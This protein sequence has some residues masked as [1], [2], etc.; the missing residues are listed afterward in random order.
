MWICGA[1]VYIGGQSTSPANIALIYAATPIGIALASAVLLR[2]RMSPGRMLGVALAL[3]GV[4]WV[5]AKGDW[6]N[7]LAVRFSIGNGW[8]VV[9]AVSWTAYSVLL[10]LWP[11]RRGMAERL[12]AITGGGIVVLIPFTA[13]EWALVAQPPFSPK[14]LG[15]AV[16]VLPG[17]VAYQAYSF[18]LREL[19][20]ARTA[21]VLYLGPVYAALSAWVLLSEPPQAHHA[22]GAALILPSIWFAT[23]VAARPA[24]AADLQARSR[25]G[26]K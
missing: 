15:L 16:A 4:L 7:L 22:M 5:I 14:A 8:I 24:V 9:A 25:S 18:M 1:F 19:G 12:V 23:R 13:L 3:A 2:E 11:S 20:A 6:R 26:D 17:M 10:R 21:L